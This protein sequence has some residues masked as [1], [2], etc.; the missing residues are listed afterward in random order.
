MNMI[1]RIE[2]FE[3]ILE[4]CEDSYFSNRK[5]KMIRMLLSATKAQYEAWLDSEYTNWCEARQSMIDEWLSALTQEQVQEWK[6]LENAGY[7]PQVEHV[8]LRYIDYPL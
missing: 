4:K 7:S 1:S 6:D 3:R 8:S 5:E 2:R